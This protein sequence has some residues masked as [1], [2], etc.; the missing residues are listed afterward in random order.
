[1][2]DKFILTTYEGIEIKQ[3]A[4]DLMEAVKKKRSDL[5]FKPKEKTDVN[6]S[7]P[8]NINYFEVFQAD[9]LD[10][11]IGALGQF[12]GGEYYVC[13]LGMENGRW[14]Y[15]APEYARKSKHI[16]STASIA[17]KNLKTPDMKYI[18][19]KYFYLF[20]NALREKQNL[21]QNMIYRNAHNAP[22]YVIDEMFKL[23]DSG[24]Q[25][26]NIKFQV[27]LDYVSQNRE[28]IVKYRD[29]DPEWCGV[30]VRPNKV[31]YRHKKGE[32][33]TVV[34]DRSQ[35][36]QNIIDKMAVLDIMTE[37]DYIEDIGLKE[38][39]NVYWVMV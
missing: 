6:R 21:V 10:Y 23:I 36:P 34:A 18:Q 12:T 16:K 29:Y 8:R 25:T 30:W 14:C 33:D 24:Y 17:I 38:K 28:M 39:D 9:D 5:V 22:D 3:G 13:Y 27:S 11:C 20:N 35:L 37:K 15:E 2:T 26:D 32:Q 19:E 1:M 31:I 4:I 7:V